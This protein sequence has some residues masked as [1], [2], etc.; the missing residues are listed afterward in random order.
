MIAFALITF[1][2]AGTPSDTPPEKVGDIEIVPITHASLV[3]KWQGK[4]VYVDP[5]RG[6]YSGQ[7]KADLIL[8]THTHGDHLDPAQIAESSKADTIIVGTEAVQEKIPQARIMKNGDRVNILDIAIEA[9]PMYN[10]VRKR[11]DGTVFHPKGEGNGYVLTF[12][13]QRVYISGDTECIPEMKALRD[14]DIAFLCMNLPYTMPP[15]EAAECVNAFRPK[16]VYPYHSRGTDLQKFK[17]EV[18]AGIEVRILDWYPN[19]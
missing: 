10:V 2:A 4:A 12:G 16:I 8:L 17:S 3:L 7:P 15:E 13:E 1:L 19:Q 5:C 6:N 14:I 11:P 18:D 9:V